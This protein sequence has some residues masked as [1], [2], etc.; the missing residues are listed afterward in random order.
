M[1]T[2]SNDGCTRC[3]ACTYCARMTMALVGLASADVA[4][5]DLQV[6]EDVVKAALSLFC[7]SPR[8][9][10]RRATGPYPPAACSE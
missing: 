9:S 7:D 8:A 4:A 10:A 6:P 5:A 3:D 1:T 2:L